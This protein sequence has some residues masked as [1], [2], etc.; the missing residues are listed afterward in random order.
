MKFLKK[1]KKYVTGTEKAGLYM[2]ETAEKWLA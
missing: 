2:L 1:M